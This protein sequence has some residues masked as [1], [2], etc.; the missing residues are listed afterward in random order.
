[1]K[2]SLLIVSVL[3][4]AAFLISCA[5]EVKPPEASSNPTPAPTLAPTPVPTIEITAAPTPAPL[6]SFTTGLPFEGEYKPVMVVIENSRAARPQLGLQTA[7]V[8]YEVPVEGS[9]TRFVCVFSDNVAEKVQPV[10]SARIPFIYLQG[11]WEGILM[12]F[13]AAGRKKSQWNRE[14]SVYGHKLYKK[15]GM[16]MDGLSGTWKNYFYRTKTAKAPHNVIGK[17]L[18]AVQLYNYEPTPPGWLFDKSHTYEAENADTVNLPMC[19][20][21]KNFVSYSYD[22]DK[23]VYLRFMNKKAFIS[24][25]TGKQVNVKNIIVQHSTYKSSSGRKLWNLVG[26]GKAE[27]YIN[28]KKIDGSWERESDNKKTVFLDSGGKQ[29]ILSPGNTWVHICP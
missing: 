12:H 26:G 24:A 20:K 19:T 15:S 11:E 1:M 28:G 23:S 14:Y 21:N 3:L 5:P 7:D 22:Q 17:P 6:T 9:I 4:A 29:I 16:V 2:R 10:R 25:E 13:G 27:F 18:N 8:V